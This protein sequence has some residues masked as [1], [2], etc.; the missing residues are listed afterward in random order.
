MVMQ[1]ERWLHDLPK[2]ELHVH[3]EGSMSVDTVRALSDRNG[4]DTSI[5]WPHG[6]PEAFSF[7][8]F[9]DFAA[10]FAFGLSLLRSADD[11]AT[12]TDDLA[13]TLAGQNVRYAEVTTTAYT[14]FRDKVDRPG[15]PQSEYRAGLNEGRRRAALRGVE[16]GWVIDIPRDIEMPDETVTIEYLESGKTP[17][18]L[19]AIGLGGYEVGF[20][21]APYASHF[22][23][24][25]SLGLPAV[26]HA[27]ETEGAH[28]VRS[29]V[30]DLGAIRIGHGVRCLEDES[31]VE[32][33]IERGIVLEV[34][35]TSNL[36]LHVVD[37]IGDHPLP[38]LI[39]AGLSVCINTDDPG[40]FATDLETELAIVTDTFGITKAQHKA[41]QRDAIAASFASDLSKS[42]L[43]AEIDLF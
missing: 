17:D 38:G 31:L 2:I 32:L 10:Q 18:G 43:S 30:E 9:P 29:A 35:P 28:S 13:A 27:G 22:A 33:L 4:V 6:L 41:F 19:I 23:R 36:L 15:M 39:D 42:K 26:P 16:I 7:D 1:F 5:V 20:P 24:A 37:Q 8:G 14:H 25:A 11:L 40:W 3:L 12:I 21:A 34:C